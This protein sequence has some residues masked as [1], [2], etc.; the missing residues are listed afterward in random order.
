MVRC[1]AFCILLHL[2]WLLFSKVNL[3]LINHPKK[4]RQLLF[5]KLQTHLNTQAQTHLDIQAQKSACACV[6]NS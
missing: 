3:K 1:I 6:R 2:I 5:P 4:Y